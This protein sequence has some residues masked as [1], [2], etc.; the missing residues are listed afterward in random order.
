MF[1]RLRAFLGR[2]T[3]RMFLCMMV[4]IAILFVTDI[5][6]RLV[7]GF[8]T[9]DL[10]FLSIAVTVGTMAGIVIQWLEERRDR[11]RLAQRAQRL[12]QTRGEEVATAEAQ[13][14]YD[15]FARVRSRIDRGSC[16]HT[17]VRHSYDA[18]TCVD[19]GQRWTVGNA[20]THPIIDQYNGISICVECGMENPIPRREEDGDE[21]DDDIADRER[22]WQLV[23]VLHDA[24]PS[25]E[26][27]REANRLNFNFVWDQHPLVDPD[28]CGHT[29]FFRLVGIRS[30]FVCMGCCSP[31]NVNE[32][33]P[34][35]TIT[36]E[37]VTSFTTLMSRRAQERVQQRTGNAAI[38]DRPAPE[39]NRGLRIIRERRFPFDETSGPDKTASLSGGDTDGANHLVAKRPMRRRSRR[40]W[41]LAAENDE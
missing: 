3:G 24:M 6:L 9:P 19:C 4:W 21:M 30:H 22:A 28:V 13:Q 5:F 38:E 34:G 37:N 11:R 14:L 8:Q 7:V 20:C 17:L 2:A 29:A 27:Y 12:A 26:A 35:V 31:I 16:D 40:G 10:L 41:G 32:P 23:S 15:L 25:T 39:R 33:P 1:R 36:E 18:D